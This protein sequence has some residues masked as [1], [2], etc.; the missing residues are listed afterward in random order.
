[1]QREPGAELGLHD[2][3]GQTLFRDYRFRGGVR[4]AELS[5]TRI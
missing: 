4:G 2:R 5:S 1:M 3:S